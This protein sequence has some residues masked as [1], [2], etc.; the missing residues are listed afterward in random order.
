MPLDI[1]FFFYISCFCPLLCCC[2][3]PSCRKWWRLVS[4]FT[5]VTSCAEIKCSRLHFSL[6]G[7]RSSTSLKPVHLTSNLKAVRGQSGADCHGGHVRHKPLLLCFQCDIPPPL[8]L[9]VIAFNQSSSGDGW[10][11]LSSGPYLSTRICTGLG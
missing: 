3:G 4:N 9:K 1:E 2:L 10:K 7:S 8:S 6:I 11:P 5:Q